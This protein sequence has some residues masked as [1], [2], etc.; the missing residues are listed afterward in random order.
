MV[1]KRT[2]LPEIMGSLCRW[3]VLLLCTGQDRY[4][5]DFL[6]QFVVEQV[7][8]RLLVPV[9]CWAGTV[10]TSCTSPLLSRYFTPTSC[11]SPLLSKYCTNFL[12][13]SVVEQVL[14]TNFLYQSVVEQVLYQLL[15]PVRCWAGTVPTFC[16]SPLL[17]K[18][19][20]NF[21]YQSVVEQV[22]VL[23]H[24]SKI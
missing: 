4:C 5:T 20:T 12:Y 23:S 11:T 10:P 3:R 9:R 21:L 6:Y 14:Y 15:V 2:N 18:Y 19:C 16:T 1:R 7:L 17:S 13:K 8:Y 24:H 22:F